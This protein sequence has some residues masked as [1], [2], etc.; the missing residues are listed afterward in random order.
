MPSARM[1]ASLR[2]PTMTSFGHFRLRREARRAGRLPSRTRDAGGERQAATARV[3]TSRSSAVAGRTR[4]RARR[5]AA[6]STPV[7]A[8]RVRPSAR[9]RRPRDLPPRLLAP[10]PRRRPSSNGHR[11][12]Q[13]RTSRRP[14]RSAEPLRPS[15]ATL[16]RRRRDE[17]PVS[18]QRL[19][20]EAESA[21]RTECVSAPTDTKSAPVGGDLGKRSS[22]T[23]PEISTIARP[24]AR[25]T[26]SR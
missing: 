24:S 25:R 22:V 14:I 5:L 26:A 3:P 23:P 6:S 15:A 2:G 11:R 12:I 9:R 17:A 16:T 7:P 1:P 20:L 18:S 10:P 21:A 13:R 8:A 19:E 4:D